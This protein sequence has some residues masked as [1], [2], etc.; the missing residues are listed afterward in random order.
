M[1]SLLD[2]DII[3]LIISVFGS[4]YYAV[5]SLIYGLYMSVIGVFN[6]LFEIVTSLFHI[7]VDVVLSGYLLFGVFP[8][9]PAYL[10]F[11]LCTI[12]IVILMVRFVLRII[13]SLP[14]VDGGIFRY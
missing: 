14:T 12:K 8:A 3:Q 7:L 9:L 2:V 1:V 10:L 5:Y 6:P 11:T 13:G 4:V